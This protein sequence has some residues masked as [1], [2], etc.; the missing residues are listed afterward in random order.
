MEDKVKKNDNCKSLFNKKK[1]KMIIIL[2]LFMNTEPADTFICK[3]SAK[4]SSRFALKKIKMISY[5]NTF[6]GL[7]PFRL[8]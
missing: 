6:G 1:F 7:E 8:I 4:N 2:K 3:V 5:A